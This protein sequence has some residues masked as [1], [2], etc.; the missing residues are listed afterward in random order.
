MG[1]GLNAPKEHHRC[2]PWNLLPPEARLVSAQSL[3]PGSCSDPVID[4]HDASCLLSHLHHWT[5][6][7][8]S[9]LVGGR[10]SILGISFPGTT[11]PAIYASRL[12]IP[13]LACPPPPGRFKG[14][15]LK[16]NMCSSSRRSSP[17]G[18]PHCSV[19]SICRSL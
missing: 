6:C 4:D 17:G 3:C 2:S 18:S 8:H 5:R 14:H 10:Q 15:A 13:P 16:L 9:W 12:P 19:S 1:P 11:V 7:G